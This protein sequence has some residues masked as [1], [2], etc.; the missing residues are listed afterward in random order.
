MVEHTKMMKESNGRTY[1]YPVILERR[2][3]R[4]WFLK[5][6]YELKDEIKAMKGAKWHGREDP[7]IKMWSVTDCARNKFQLE[8]LTGGNP[9]AHFDKPLLDIEFD[10][11]LF[12]HQKTMVRH[13]LTYNHLI[14]AADLGVGKTV[15]GI[16]I[17]ERSSQDD[18]WWV[19]PKSALKAV[20]R[21][22]VKWD[23]KVTPRM[24]TYQGLVKVMKNWKSGDPAP[25][26]V[27]F[28]ESSRLKGPTSQRTQAAMGLADAMR[29]E[30]EYDSYIVLM[31]GA[32][33]PKSPLGWFSQCEI[34]CPGFIREGSPKAFE[35]RLGLYKKEMKVDGF[36]W[37]RVTWLDDEDKCN[38]CGQH[39]TGAE[40]HDF[41]K[42]INEVSYLYERMHGLVLP[43]LK[44]DVLD[45][46]ELQHR[47]IECK[48][49]RTITRVAKTLKD[50]APTAIQ[51][52][53]WLRELSDGFQYRQVKV[54]TKPCPVCDG[55]DE[56]CDG[57][58]GEGVVD[59]M[60][61]EANQIPCPKDQVVKELLEE[62]EEQGRIVIF[63]GFTGSIDRVRELCIGQGWDVAQVDGRGWKVYGQDGIKNGV[64]VLDHWASDAARVAF[65]A[66]PQSGGM[67]LTLTESRMAVFY[68]NDFNPESRYQA[69]GRIHRPGMDYNLG[70]TI[71][72]IDHLPTD[73]YIRSIL[74][75]NRRLE[76]MT[77]GE[78]P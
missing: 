46:P 27:I 43:F 59:V 50:I 44:K 72:D 26:G 4:I 7:P 11:P 36:Y 35:F 22:F 78:M 25:H 14:L 60:K 8:Y 16:E 45:L 21:E 6:P 32:P 33:S 42:S 48:P 62:V 10:R 23:C 30:W 52:L 51:A 19:G 29:L 40:D 5:A 65:V 77:L 3:G 1:L 66:H 64:E 12:E 15:A 57:C 2:N 28:D 54:G 70:A 53:T 74:D 76:L 58:E 63:A 41:V 49:T 9:Y 68:S 18:F 75:A 13:V 73:A 61:S 20:E 24:L 34:A 38:V 71:V 39:H 67:G 69:K 37:D 47:V 31:S 56:D 17:M 55:T